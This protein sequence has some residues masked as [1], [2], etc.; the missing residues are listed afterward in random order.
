LETVNPPTL[1]DFRV[2][3][4]TALEPWFVDWLAALSAEGL[5]TLEPGMREGTQVKAA[6]SGKSFRRQETWREHRQAARKQVEQRGDPR[7]AEVS[8]RPAKARQQAARQ[9]VGQALPPKEKDAPPVSETDPEAR[10][11][12][13]GDGGFAPNPNLQI[14]T[15]HG[16]IVGAGV[17]PAGS[18]P[19]QFR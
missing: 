9:K 16:I 1:S 10:L 17:T 12:K 8:P 3:P 18:D 2:P 15:D 11:L 5:T 7:Q 14:A 19:R 13:P 4:Q 6:A